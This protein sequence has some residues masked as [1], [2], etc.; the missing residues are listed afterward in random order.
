M[1]ILLTPIYLWR[2]FMEIIFL[3]LF[4]LFFKRCFFLNIKTFFLRRVLYFC[5][6]RKLWLWLFKIEVI[7]IIFLT[8]L[9][10]WGN[11]K[12]S[13]LFQ[14]CMKGTR[15]WLSIN[16]RIFYCTDINYMKI[17]LLSISF[18]VLGARYALSCLKYF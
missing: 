11:I 14:R 9:L 17:N 18:E 15:I 4:P 2:F 8:L 3:Y 16:R 13:L 1:T 7:T 6:S 12:R 5:N 10:K